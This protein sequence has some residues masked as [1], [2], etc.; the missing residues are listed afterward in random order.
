MAWRRGTRSSAS[1]RSARAGRFANRY[2]EAPWRSMPPHEAVRLN[3]QGRSHAQ[4]QEHESAEQAYRAAISA[5]PTWSVPWFNLGLLHKYR[6][7]WEESFDAYLRATAL[8]PD[9][10][11]AW[12]NLGISATF[13]GRWE[14][15]RAAWARCGVDVGTD[16]GP[17]HMK[18]GLVPIRL[19][20]GEVV[21]SH[22]IDPARAVIDN[23]PLPNSG[24][25][26]REVWLHDGAPNGHRTLHGREVPV[27]D[28]LARLE[29]SP[30]TT[31]ILQVS[32]PDGTGAA[33]SDIATALGGAAEDWSATTRVLCRACSEGN[34]DHEAHGH[35]RQGAAPDIGIAARD[36]DHAQRIV[37]AWR[38]AHPGVY[39]HSIAE[40]EPPNE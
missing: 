36:I 4:A 14:R 33:L 20:A 6:G 13:L 31:F 35:L 5:A 24:S 23:V 38:S 21:W 19:P 7:Q 26:W 30:F 16:S 3:E 12:W 1:R 17:V 29:T 8:D 27:F 11:A 15:A 9:D 10:I 28:A 22:R 34:P 25:R 37:S 39:I 40:A 18:L 32:A 2:S